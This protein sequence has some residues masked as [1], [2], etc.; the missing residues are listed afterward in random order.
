MQ[1]PTPRK[2]AQRI[3]DIPAEVLVA[4]N[5]GA[6]ESVNLVEWLASGANTSKPSK[7]R[8]NQR[9]RCSNRFAPKTGG[10]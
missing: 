1:N 2:G 10:S 9:C 6:I 5:D 4:L 3:R 7:P 8:R